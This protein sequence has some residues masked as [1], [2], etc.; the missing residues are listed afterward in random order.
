MDWQTF[1]LLAILV[2]S[3]GYFALLIFSFIIY[4]FS[5]R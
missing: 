2:L 4:W 1:E 3:G 5:N